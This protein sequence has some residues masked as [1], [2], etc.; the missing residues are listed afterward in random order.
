VFGDHAYKVAISSTKSMTGH[1][2]CAA[3]ALNLLAA[4][5]AISDGVVPPTINLET[6]DP[7]CD[8]DYVP[9]TARE[10]PVTAALVNSFAFGGTNGCL[11]VASPNGAA[12]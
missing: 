11:V 1:L 4:T 6:P 3:G 10:M 7:E 2:T 12:A 8:L 5:R 9:N